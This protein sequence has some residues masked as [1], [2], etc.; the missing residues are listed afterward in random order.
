MFPAH[1]CPG[2]HKQDPGEQAVLWG[3]G[4]W[5]RAL[6]CSSEGPKGCLI[7]CNNEGTVGIRSYIKRML[8]AKHCVYIIVMALC[9]SIFVLTMQK[10]LYIYS[11]SPL[12]GHLSNRDRIIWQQ[13]L[14]N[15]FNPPSHQRTPLLWGQNY[16]AERVSL[17]EGEYYTFYK[18][19]QF[20]S[21]VLAQQGLANLGVQLRVKSWKCSFCAVMAYRLQD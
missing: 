15:A 6:A 2:S 8:I 14:C 1:G 13:V 11:S 4:E 5:W 21:F 10:N 19:K 3:K 18:S 9:F 7:T 12:K 16:L 17:L 20:M